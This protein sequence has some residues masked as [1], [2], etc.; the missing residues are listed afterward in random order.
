MLPNST[1]EKL[2]WLLI[3]VGLLTLCL[4]VFLHRNEAGLGWMVMAVGG[5]AV[6]LGIVLVWVRSRRPR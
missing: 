4:G 5:V 3:Y 6:A 2:I 1:L